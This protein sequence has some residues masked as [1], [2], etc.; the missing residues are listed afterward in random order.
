MTTQ[1]R[2]QPGLLPLS[3]KRVRIGSRHTPRPL[4]N[5]QR[6]QAFRN[7]VAPVVGNGYF[8]FNRKD[9]AA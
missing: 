8:K 6:L 1:S 5:E 7:A 3:L 2:P 9:R 4:T